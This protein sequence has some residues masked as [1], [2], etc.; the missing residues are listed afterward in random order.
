MT[1]SAHGTPA[2]LKNSTWRGHGRKI[3]G[4]LRDQDAYGLWGGTATI[5]VSSLQPNALT[6]FDLSLSGRTPAW[7]TIF[8]MAASRPTADSTEFHNLLADSVRVKLY[9]YQT[10]LDSL[11]TLDPV[12]V[13]VTNSDGSLSQQYQVVPGTGAGEAAMIYVPMTTDGIHDA[14][15]TLT[16]MDG[17]STVGLGAFTIVPEPGTLT[18]LAAAVMSIAVYIWRHRA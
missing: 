10:T 3:L 8:A 15:V 16:P 9:C 11:S 12:L 1:S 14:T 17:T 7:K 5:T 4:V 18:L 2:A 13:Q 6:A